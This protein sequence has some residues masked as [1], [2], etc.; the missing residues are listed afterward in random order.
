M[1]PCESGEFPTSTLWNTSCL[2]I[3]TPIPENF[4]LKN[5]YPN[6]FNPVVNI[7]YAISTSDLVNINIY[8]LNGQIVE[9]LFSG[10]QSVGS[11]QITWNA[12]EMSSGIYLI[13][14]Q[15]G[16]TMISDELVLLK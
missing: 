12:S 16:N 1:N 15:S 11:Y 7:E 4:S 13:M 14:I 2:S 9:V 5:I 10:H 3:E 8:D 6:P